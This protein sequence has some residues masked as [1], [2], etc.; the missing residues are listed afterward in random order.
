MELTTHCPQCA[1]SF[2]VSEDQLALAQ[3]WVR[4]G[5]CQEVFMAQAH[6]VAPV[7]HAAAVEEPLLHRPE[8]MALDELSAPLDDPHSHVLPAAVEG[9]SER[10]QA[11][12]APS[13]AYK[14]WASLGAIAIL[15]A[16]L[17][18]Q[19]SVD[20]YRGLADAQPRLALWLQ[21]LCAPSRC[22]QRQS[23]SLSIDESSLTSSGTNTFR[24]QATISNRSALYLEAP[25]LALTLTDAAD[26]VLARKVYAPREWMAQ[27]GVLQSASTTPVDYWIKWDN[28]PAKA[29]VAGYR[30][31]AFY[32]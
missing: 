13:K 2:L 18:T 9:P 29:R 11:K 20:V 1:T 25:F 14:R 5:V 22:A 28:M 19:I 6:T 12:P 3:G 23:S 27:V 10:P 8:T 26:E 32:P 4:C 17:G 24:L 21:S 31:Q 16:A 7:T 30:L 15:L